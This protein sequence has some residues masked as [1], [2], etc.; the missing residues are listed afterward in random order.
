MF[1]SSGDDAVKF[2]SPKKKKKRVDCVLQL[3]KTGE[4]QI[5]SDQVVDDMVFFLK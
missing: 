5:I 2:S 3:M 4:K 1:K